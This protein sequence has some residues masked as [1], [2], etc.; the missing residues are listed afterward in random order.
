MDRIVTQKE[1][2]SFADKL[3]QHQKGQ[4]TPDM[5]ILDKAI[6]EHNIVS[7]SK[8]FEEVSYETLIRMLDITK[9]QT[10]RI[11]HTMISE[12]RLDA[13]ID[14]VEGYVDFTRRFDDYNNWTQGINHFCTTLD[15]LI[16]K[17]SH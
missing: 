14:Q 10:E 2:T 12:K 15:R 8:L 3:S 5:S 13:R 9:T 17:V 7:I 11:I 16:T 4:V 1:K 6:I